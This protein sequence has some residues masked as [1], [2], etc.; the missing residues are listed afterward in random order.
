MIFERTRYI[1]EILSLRTRKRLLLVTGM[2][3]AGKTACLQAVMKR[4]REEKPPVRIVHTSFGKG[5]QTAENLISE[6]KSLGVGSSAL[7]IDRAD[8]ITGLSAALSDILLN[9]SGSII[10]TGRDSTFLKAELERYFPEEMAVM[11]IRPLSYSDYL[12]AERKRDSREN[13][14]QY[15]RFGG[16]PDIRLVSGNEEASRRLLDLQANSFI[17]SGILEPYPVRNA[18]HIRQ[19]L[20]LVA[21]HTGE[22]LSARDIQTA[23]AHEKLTISPQA[24]LDYLGYC[25]SSGLIENIPVYDIARREERD[26]GAVWYFGDSGMRSAF[27]GMQGLAERDRSLENLVYLRLSD[28]GWTIRRGRLDRSGVNRE[29]VTFVCEKKG[30]RVYVQMIGITTGAAARLARYRTLLDI[31]DAWPK[32]IVQ[33]ENE[34]DS[35]DGIHYRT[36]REILL[37]G[38]DSSR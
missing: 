31:R 16:L 1:D 35:G 3:G 25:Q 4:L 17:L 9:H 24:A 37:N 20:T 26:Q 23:F 19:L 2:Q 36:A 14:E 6:A 28:D 33:S 15:M 29:D 32:M 18:R 7:F 8:S 21:R 12:E 27:S 5:C 38:I 13:L 22:N 30:C 11:R 10:M 34:K